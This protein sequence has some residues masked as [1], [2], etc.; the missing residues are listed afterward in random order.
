[1]Y[2]ETADQYAAILDDRFD[3]WDIYRAAPMR[4][5]VRGD[6]I[7]KMGDDGH[8][9]RGSTILEALRVASE[10]RPL[11]KVPRCPKPLLR[12]LFEPYKS[13]SKWRLNYDGRDFAVRVDTKRRAMEVA[14]RMVKNQAD[15]I[16][17]WV[18]ETL[19]QI[20]GLTENIDFIW[21]I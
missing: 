6:W 21:A 4:D 7:V 5:Q 11:P 3:R 18:R 14:D 12:E 15:E 19:P 8:T 16:E 10:F 17:R 2:N 13:G 1:M 20:T 9:K